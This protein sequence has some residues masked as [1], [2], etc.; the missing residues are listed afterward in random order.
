[1]K[2]EFLR[3]QV[4][5]DF[6]FYRIRDEISSLCVT[7]EGKNFLLSRESS[8]DL[9]QFS[10]LK[11]LGREWFLYLNSSHPQA[12]S[13]F[14]PVKDVFGFLGVEGALLNHE[15]IFALGLFS[16]YSE[17]MK[18]CIL[19]AG[20]D[21]EIKNL[22]DIAVSLPSLEGA[23]NEIFAILDISTGQIRDLPSLR[24]IRSRISQLK[25]EIEN[26]IRK[27]TS[28]SSLQGAL[29]SNVP[30]YRAEREL[31]AVRSDHRK[32]ISGIV[33]EVSGTGQTLYI[34]P[35]EI[36]RANN[37]LLEAENDL[38]LE[39]NRIFR[40]L[41]F[42]LGKYRE[43]FAACHE[44]VLLLDSTY[45][46]AKYAKKIEGV[47]AEDADLELEA[48]R[49]V[50]ARHPL[51][52]EK[53]VPV[54]INFVTGK[55]IMIVTGPNTGGKTVTLKTV[56]LFVLLNQ[57]GFPLP[58]AEGTRLPVF[59]SIFADIGDDQSIDQNLSTFSSRMKN[60]ALTLDNANSK[61]LVLLDE[62]GSGTDPLEGSA[63]SM[64]ILD[65]LIEK[66]AFVLVTT[67][68]GVLKNYGY[69]N[70]KC[71]NASVEFNSE[72]LKPTYRLLMGVPGESHALEIACHSGVSATLIEK[73]R[74]YI[75]TEQAD[76]SS[77]IKGL[78]A[79]H[80]EVEKLISEHEKKLD[81][82][83]NKEIK[84]HEREIRMK[85]REI[86][87]LEM[88][89]SQSSVFLRE[90]RSMLENLVR[91]LREGE[92]TREKTLSVKN[93]ISGLSEK[94]EG[95]VEVIK[96]EKKNLADEKESFVAE[97]GIRIQKMK[98]RKNRSSSKKSKSRLSNQEALKNAS[99]N[100][101]QKNAKENKKKDARIVLS[102]GMDVYVGKDRKKGVLA[103]S[104]KDGKWQV[105]FGSIKMVFPESQIVPC[106]PSVF[107][108]K[109]SYVF[110]RDYSVH[111]DDEKPKFEL[112]LLGMRYEE[113]LKELEHQMDLCA[114][115]NF[116]NF[117]VIHG[118]G[119]G[120]LQQG[121]LNYLSHSGIVKDYHFASPEDGGSGKTYVELI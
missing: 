115:H 33:H 87:L 21:L 113:A 61:S 57:A 120:A 56:A 22:L 6:D 72:T 105:Q 58:C 114:I 42:S 89:H 96:E 7:E 121:V 12:L 73:A 65:T 68:H 17:K 47:F 18:K 35:D 100:E 99:V 82:L 41:A 5:S 44:S 107:D 31:L 94:I 8:S 81:E 50:E 75:S 13:N 11:T 74:N 16:V 53:A 92:I 85:E 49:I 9:R 20:E 38:Q 15:Q 40:E 60:I 2:D 95:Q 10:Y 63:I 39:I 26:A 77:L 45:A 30:V 24:A 62:L 90:T 70:P 93:F 29:Q 14:P 52:R 104:Q 32:D 48:P 19:A 84:V 83:M 43:D 51:L 64:A 103:R 59:E 23:A 112:R 66:D 4:A 88:E 71:I 86:E 78:T 117:S 111:S 67:H 34:E 46:A 119:T 118:K 91:T 76:V 28:D 1:M 108:S 106:E 36:V 55:K 98:D 80:E 116:K 110:E 25:R 37:E 54:T 101:Y 3:G 102:E 69:M 97:N 79:K 27:Y 109:A